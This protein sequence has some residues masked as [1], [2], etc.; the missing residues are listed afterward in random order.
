MTED[1]LQELFDI[2][3]QSL[4]NEE[5]PEQRLAFEQWRRNEVKQAIDAANKI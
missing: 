3:V 5:A 1:R 2:V 4:P